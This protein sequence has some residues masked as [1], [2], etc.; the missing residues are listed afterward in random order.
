MIHLSNDDVTELLSM[1]ETMNAL[2]VGFGQLATRDAAHVPRLELWSPAAQESGYHCLGSMSGT[3]KQ[4]GFSALRIKSDV[5]TWPEGKRQEKYAV[6]PGT[7]CGFILLFSTATGEPVAI[8]NDGVLQSMRVGASAG[9]AVDHLAN[10]GASS[11][12]IL[13]SGTMARVHLDAISRTRTLDQVTV[14]SPTPENR[15]AFATRC[16]H[17]WA[18]RHPS[19]R[20][21]KK[22]VRGRDIV[23]ST[24]NAMEPTM[25]PSGSRTE[26]WSWRS[27]GARS[28]PASWIGP[29]VSSNSPPTA[30][31]RTRMSQT[32]SGRRAAPEVLW[33]A[34]TPNATDSRGNI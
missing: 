5:L 30:S 16:R 10:P 14:Y 6:E 25:D 22:R 17:A 20:A 18:S 31:G 11:I 19:V 28:A 32:S 4:F 13:G 9:I 12:G 27:P 15:E 7:Y 26:L 3:T 24:T 2:R 29:I 34:A 21:P 1:Q 8:I 33:R 23:V